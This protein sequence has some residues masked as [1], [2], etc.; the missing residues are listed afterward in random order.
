[1]SAHTLLK[2][3]ACFDYQWEYRSGS[4]TSVLGEN[5]SGS[6][7]NGGMQ[8][9]LDPPHPVLTGLTVV[10]GLGLLEGSG[11][12]G[13]MRSISCPASTWQGSAIRHTPGR[14]SAGI[15]SLRRPRANPS[16]LKCPHLQTEY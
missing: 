9:R 1:M 11:V 7:R 13:A 4:H 14:I 10:A 3:L 5:L 2:I 16:E 12:T 8:E 6:G 15:V